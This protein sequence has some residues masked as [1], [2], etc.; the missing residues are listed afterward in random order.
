MDYLD[1]LKRALNITWRYRPLWLFGFLLALC[2]GTGSGGSNFNFPT[3]GGGGDEGDAEDLA[4]LLWLLDIDP[5]WII[6]L[7]VGFICL[8]L[9]LI[10]L[11]IVV[12]TVT[13]TA[14]IGMVAQISETGAVTLSDGWRFG[15]SGAAW[16][17]FLVGLVITIPVVIITIGLIMLALSP[18][19]LLLIEDTVFT[20]IAII[21]TIFSVFMIIFVLIAMSAVLMPILELA[22]RQTAL[23]K[24]GVL[25]SVRTTFTFIKNHLK[26]VVLIW[27]LMFGAGIA[28]FMAA[29]IILF[30]S[31]AAAAVVG[32]VPALIVYL[33]SESTLGAAV[34]GIPLA[35][36]IFAL[37][38][39]AGNAFYLIFQSAVWTLTYLDLLKTGPA[40][41][42]EPLPSAGPQVAA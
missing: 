2:G 41:G 12:Q 31:L 14:L 38:N 3:G 17:V 16:R 7:A 8:I 5:N 34:A 24:A 18:L 13:R 27:L 4:E 20:V 6:A 23:A 40:A 28:W 35:V 1:I 21:L 10:V 26:D 42:P 37:I 9:L 32:G 11:G 15:W 30:I 39:S 29:I 19:L 33:L 36:I 25:V 22:W